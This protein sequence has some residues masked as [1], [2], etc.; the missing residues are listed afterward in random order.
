MARTGAV[1]LVCALVI[2]ACGGP[3]AEDEV[4]KTLAGYAKAFAEHDYQALCDTYFDPKVVAGLEATGLPCEAALRPAVGALKKPTLA[5]RSVKVDGDRATAAV[6]TT[7][8]N[9]P[10]ADVTLALLHKDG[11]WRIASTTAAGPKP[12]GP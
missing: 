11:R 1:V 6:H 2:G 8:E 5:V 12:A 9:E 7:A 10:P 3:S 4:R